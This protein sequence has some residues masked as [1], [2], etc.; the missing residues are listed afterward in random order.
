MPLIVICP[1]DLEDCRRRECTMDGCRHTH[2][3]VLSPCAACGDLHEPFI[4]PPMCAACYQRV[5]ISGRP[6]A[7]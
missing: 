6:R 2:T 4:D 5:A 1:L 3:P 7:R